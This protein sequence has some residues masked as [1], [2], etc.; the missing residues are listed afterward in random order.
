MTTI[1]ILSDTHAWW[2]ER[3]AKYLGDCD[4]IWHAGDI[5]CVDVIRQL[6]GVCPVVRA[7]HGNIDTGECRRYFP[8]IQQFKVEDVPVFMTHIGGYPGRYQPG[9]TQML[10]EAGARIFVCGH[11]H[12][13]KVIYDDRL[14]C[15]HINPG[16]AGY[17]GWQQQRTLVKVD[18]DGATPRNLEV[19]ELGGRRKF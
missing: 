1:G 3:Y 13:L 12:I 19:I 2:D 5:G 16:A 4:E 9:I 15:L 11:S 8:E 18:I 17:S 7:V 6:E 14:N 10:Y